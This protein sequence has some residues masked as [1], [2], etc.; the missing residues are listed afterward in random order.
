MAR[1]PAADQI[2]K[3]GILGPDPTGRYIMARQ[4]A[5]AFI[6]PTGREIIARQWSAQK[7]IA[8]SS[9]KE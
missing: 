4:F 1:D 5:A 6:D 9:V 2:S 3:K 7:I 8:P